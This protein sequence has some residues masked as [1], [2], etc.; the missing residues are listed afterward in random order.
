M[1]NYAQFCIS[2]VLAILSIALGAYAIFQSKRYNDASNKT[3]KETIDLADTMRKKLD[4]IYIYVRNDAEIHGSEETSGR[5]VLNLSKDCIVF[6]KTASFKP[7]KTAEIISEM[8]ELLSPILKQTYIDHVNAFI[9]GNT[10]N[11]ECIVCLRNEVT[12]ISDKKQIEDIR[13]KI[14]E[15]GLNI[16]I[17]FNLAVKCSEL[18]MPSVILL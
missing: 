6:N 13:S 7:N 10:D 12:K 11:E 2:L 3:N 4:N 8:Q 17:L 9:E 18:H 16:S 5:I 1:S 15:Y 14:N